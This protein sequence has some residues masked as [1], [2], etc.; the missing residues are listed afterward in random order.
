[1]KRAF[2]FRCIGQFQRLHGRNGGQFAVLGVEQAGRLR[3]QCQRPRS[4]AAAVGLY[5][6]HCRQQACQ[7]RDRQQDPDSP[8]RP[9]L[10]LPTRPR[11]TALREELQFGDRQRV[12]I[13]PRLRLAEAFSFPDTGV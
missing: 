7:D 5:P 8:I 4:Q 3:S 10:L 12:Y 13:R 1:M 2:P 11:P 6:E 9:R